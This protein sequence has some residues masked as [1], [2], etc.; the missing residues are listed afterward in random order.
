MILWTF[1]EEWFLR[2]LE[3]RGRIR[4]RWRKVQANWRPAYL[5]MARQMVRRGCCAR[6]VA[7]IWAWHSCGAVGRAPDETTVD[8]YYCGLAGRTAYSIEMDVPERLVLLSSYGVWNEILDEVIVAGGGQ[9]IGIDGEE[10]ELPR[11]ENWEDV[12][13]VRLDNR[14]PWGEANHYD[15]QACIPY[16]DH[17]WIR[18]IKRYTSP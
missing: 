16:V 12:F 3:Q 2:S 7:P 13:C 8:S 10:T 18:G 17:E 15:I 5:W 4:A 9:V 6:P 14:E 11:V 1:Q